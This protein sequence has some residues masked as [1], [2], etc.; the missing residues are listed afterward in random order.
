MLAI[1]KSGFNRYWGVVLI[2]VL[3]QAWVTIGQ[4]NSI[5]LPQP[6]N[7]LVDLVSN[8]GVYAVNGVQTLA[9][10]V[11]GLLLGMA[12]GSLLAILCWFSR[13]A[14]GMLVPLAMIFSSVPVVALIP[15]I[16]RLLGYDIK[17]VLAIVVIVSFFPAFVF[18]SAGMRALPSGSIDLFEVLGASRWTRFRHLVLPAA[19]PNWMIA[20]RLAAPSAVLSAMLAE[21]LMGQAG[22]GYLFH[23]AAGDFD[24]ER[25]FGTSVIA[26]VVSVVTFTLSQRAERVINTRWK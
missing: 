4:L 3:W 18:T 19:V 10:A 21:F 14:T 15:I 5:V 6:F 17:T 25:A 11:V 23:Q 13:L 16:A 7:V 8:P 20:V 1:L 22:L 9:L 2:L 26:T 12:C 24:M